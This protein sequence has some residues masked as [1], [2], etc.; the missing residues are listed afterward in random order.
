M[1]KFF[2][3]LFLLGS[4]AGYPV[5]LVESGHK[6]VTIETVADEIIKVEYTAP[7]LVFDKTDANYGSSVIQINVVPTR[8]MLDQKN[9][10]SMI[11]DRMHPTNHII[12]E[13]AGVVKHRAEFEGEAKICIRVNMNM[14]KNMGK[15]VGSNQPLRFG[16]NVFKDQDSE[17]AVSAS[18]VDNHLSH[19][20]REMKSMTRTMKYLV[21]EATLSKEHDA[22]FHQETVSMHSATI[23][24]PIVQ[25]CV[26]VMTG[27]TQVSHIT[28]FFKTRRII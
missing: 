21:S 26:L 4:T 8:R 6:C 22:Q 2:S 17:D 24:W 16:L 9:H 25:V 28:N 14:G 7:D 27:F 13:P 20:E 10:P 23:F 3:F 18:E 11:K 15:M 5:L 12:E 19:M 1:L